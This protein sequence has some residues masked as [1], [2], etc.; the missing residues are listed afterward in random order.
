MSLIYNEY[1]FNYNFKKYVDEYCKDKKCDL[2][3]AFEDEQ[4]K[5]MFWR[6]TEL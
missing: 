5:R 3:D 4:V 6:Y 2:K 1:K